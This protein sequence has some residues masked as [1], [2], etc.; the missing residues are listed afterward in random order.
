MIKLAK[1]FFGLSISL[2]TCFAHEDINR[3]I[4]ELVANA[5]Q[6]TPETEPHHFDGQMN[7][8]SERLLNLTRR[9]DPHA[10]MPDPNN[11]R[12]RILNAAI[13]EVT[14]ESH[15]R[16]VREYI[17]LRFNNLG[18]LTAAN[19][20]LLQV[21]GFEVDQEYCDLSALTQK[22]LPD[23]DSPSAMYNVLFVEGVSGLRRFVQEHADVHAAIHEADR[24]AVNQAIERLVE[25]GMPR[26]ELLRGGSDHVFSLLNTFTKQSNSSSL[27]HLEVFEPV[28]D[29]Q[30]ATYQD[31]DIFNQAV[32]RLV[33]LGMSRD[34]LDFNT[35]DEVLSLLNTFTEQG[36]SSL[37]PVRV[38]AFEPVFDAQPA[39]YQDKYTFD[40]AIE[41]LVRDFKENKSELLLRG[42]VEVFKLLAILTGENY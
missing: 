1:I 39:I 7:E 29:A 34:E 17:E 36:S 4:E 37:L 9:I 27:P 6:F 38:E 26:D 5:N 2:A 13:N 15:G 18:D 12:Q 19:D 42:S 21:I 30:S 23:N 24:N 32:E 31:E 10:E 40:E 3:E 33:E 28:F 11:V 22:L 41:I 16:T 20:L 8:W 25:L 14:N 35:R